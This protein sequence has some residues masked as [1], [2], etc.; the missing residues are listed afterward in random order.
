MEKLDGKALS[1]E[2]RGGL[3]TRVE[4]WVAKGGPVPCL[5][6]VLVGDDPA[7]QVYVSHK[8]KACAQAGIR[9]IEERLPGSVTQDELL[10]KV[11]N[12]N[13][14]P[15]V[16]GI[17]VQLPLPSHI[18][19]AAV[20]D[21]IDPLKDADGLC[22][23]N[24]GLLAAGR[25]R[26]APCTP[27]GVIHLLKKHQIE[28]AGANAVVVGRSQ[29]VGKPMALLLLQENA[30]VTICHSKTKNLGQHLAQADIVVVAAGRPEFLGAGDFPKNCVIV[31][32]GIHRK[33]NGKLCGDVRFAEVAETARAV[34]PVPGGVG[35]MT[36]AMLLENTMQLTMLQN[37]GV[38]P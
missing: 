23:E 38:T 16:N 32:V 8:I 9:S 6:V 35:P 1:Q 37:P 12:L 3:K 20:V 18:D 31:D 15:E 14:D 21:Q 26:V 22:T 33:D 30:T 25:M 10:A 24:L 28:M 7:S 36:I 2:W 11:N 19:E 17:L 4:Q 13:R 27:H 29:I 34:S 5:A